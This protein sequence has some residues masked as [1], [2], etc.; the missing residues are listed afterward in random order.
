MNVVV[1]LSVNSNVPDMAA[2]GS[3]NV[4]TGSPVLTFFVAVYLDEEHFLQQK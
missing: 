4:I 2:G 3:F 1:A